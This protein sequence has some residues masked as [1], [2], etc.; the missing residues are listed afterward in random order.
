MTQVTDF[1]V[2]PL[3]GCD[4]VL[5]VQWLITLGAI[6]WNFQELSMQFNWKGKQVVWKG[7]QPGQ[8]LIMSK[9]QTSKVNYSSRPGTYAMM[10]TRFI[11]DTLQMNIGG[12]SPLPQDFLLLLE[13]YSVIFEV[14]KG[15]TF[16]KSSR[17]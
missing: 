14:P 2:L 12:T 8:V 10:V 11:Q 9:K 1:L 15:L 16:L 13:Q 6:V 4:A 17:S 5:G 7:M 3:K